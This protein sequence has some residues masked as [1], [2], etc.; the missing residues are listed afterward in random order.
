M[1]K[2]SAVIIGAGNRGASYSETMAS[3]P[4]KFQVVAVADVEACRREVVR[5]AHGFGEDM[6]FSTWEELLSRPKMADLATICTMSR[7]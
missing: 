1:K 4:E 6:C 2:I 7:L 5:K 3:M